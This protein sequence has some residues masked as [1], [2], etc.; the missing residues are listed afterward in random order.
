MEKT[1]VFHPTFLEKKS[2]QV[3][4]VVVLVREVFPQMPKNL[5]NKAVLFFRIPPNDGVFV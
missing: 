5:A 4:Q 3:G 2:P 1:G